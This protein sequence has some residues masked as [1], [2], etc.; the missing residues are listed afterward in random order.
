MPKIEWDKIGERLYETGID[1]VVLYDLIDGA[2]TNGV[3]WNGVT[4]MN[5]N[6]SGAE[7]SPL[8]ADNIKY[9][10]LKSI[11]EYGLTLECYTYPQE[12]EKCNGV[13]Q[14][15][16]GVTIGQQVRNS[17]GLSFRTLIGNDVVGENFGYKLHLVYGCDASPS[18]ESNSTIN[19]SPEAKTLSYEITTTPVAV[20]NARNTSCVTINSTECDAEKLAALEKIL[21]GD[22]ENTPRLPLPDEIATIFAEG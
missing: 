4:S 11:E 19:D 10:V 17:F 13:T 20:K 9:L 14:L 8:Y 12:F 6:K 22:E 15:A 1:H 21:Y 16:K 18:E 7:P 3:A 5:E 2:Y